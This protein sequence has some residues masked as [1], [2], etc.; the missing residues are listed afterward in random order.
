MDRTVKETSV[1]PAT[2][3]F[4]IRKPYLRNC[5]IVTAR[6]LGSVAG[7]RV[8]MIRIAKCFQVDLMTFF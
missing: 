1:S 5:W 2:T 6:A 8:S 4:Q 3:V 7:R